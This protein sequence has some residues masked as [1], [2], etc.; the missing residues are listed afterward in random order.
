MS[1]G[2]VKGKNKMP[3]NEKWLPNAKV[4]DVSA[5]HS[6]PLRVSSPVRLLS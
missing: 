3:S 6:E 2:V 5:L 1:R 4:K